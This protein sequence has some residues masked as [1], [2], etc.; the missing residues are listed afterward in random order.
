MVCCDEMCLMQRE[1]APAKVNL[2]LEVGKPET[3]G[4]HPLRSLTVFAR[5]VADEV[6]FE[7]E[8]GPGLEVSGPMAGALAGEAAGDNL[9][10]RAQAALAQRVGVERRGRF[11]LDKHIPVAA[12]LGGGSA[13]AGAALRLLARSWGVTDEGLLL[14]VAAGL[15]GDVPACVLSVPVM[16][17]GQGERVRRVDGLGV[18]HGVLVNPGVACPT[19]PVFREL[20]RMGTWSD[21]A[22]EDGAYRFAPCTL[23]GCET[24]GALLERVV[25]GRN[26]LEAPAMALVPVIADVLAA[27]RGAGARVAR[28]SGSGASVLALWEDRAGAEAGAR[29]VQAARADWWVRV[30]DL[31]SGV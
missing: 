2:T 8:G 13:D 11:H 5:E 19:G 26:D 14:E 24:G 17:E 7:P 9:V 29:A 15:G 28:V 23:R 31:G 21:V 20:D 16:M 10:L 6:G 18:L 22:P 25:A 12:G 30:S 1:R 3:D 27:C 4:R